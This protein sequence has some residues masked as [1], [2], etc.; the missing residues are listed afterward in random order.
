MLRA[1]A[2]TEFGSPRTFLVVETAGRWLGVIAPELGN[3]RV[4]WV[5]SA[6]KGLRTARAAFSVDVDVSDRRLIVRS[7]DRVLRSLLVGVGS[8][9]TPT[10]T[11]QFSITDKLPGDRYSSGY[12]CCI[13]ALSG[14]Q[15]DLLAGWRGG[16]R[17]AIHGPSST[18]SIG[19]A[20]STGCLRAGEADLR[21]LMQT[22]PLGT[23]VTIRP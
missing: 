23:P 2:Q 21:Y 17:L 13:L 16:D 4:G 5:D 12:G 6:S 19:R 1:A 20:A 10:P 7:G 18:S 14:H 11:G 9:T 3:G 15:P 8:S 22:L